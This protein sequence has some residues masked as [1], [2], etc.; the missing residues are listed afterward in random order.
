MSPSLLRTAHFADDAV[1]LI[2]DAAGNAIE[3][4]GIFRLALAGGN[5]PRIVHAALVANDRGLDWS[6][7]QFTFGDERC[8][9][10][11][12]ADSNYRMAKETLFDRVSVPEGNIF[13]V[14]GEIAP[15]QAARDY[16]ARL[17]A[18]ASRF[19]EPRYVHDLILLGMGEDGHTASLFPGSAA[20]DEVGRNVI[21][22]TG[23]KPPP[24][25]IT[26][27]FP[28]LNAARRVCFLVNDA[29]KI[30]LVESIL[31]GGSSLPAARVQ[32][33]SGRVVWLVAE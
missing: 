29:G 10:P 4:R 24:Q 12:S 19:G 14:R 11:E 18:V 32:P 21:P 23:P 26:M 5:T 1:A 17:A 20:L 25:R 31:A 6:K 3:R 8:V 2:L 15:E 33:A 16:E 13:R 9:P 7:W 27:T 28:L 22:A 30:P